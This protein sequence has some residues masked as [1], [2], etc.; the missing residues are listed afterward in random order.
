MSVRWTKIDV[1][2]SLLYFA[3]TN[4]FCIGKQHRDV[5]SLS[6]DE[7]EKYSKPTNEIS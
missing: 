1:G 6:N 4:C 5:I 7:E 3:K 2:A